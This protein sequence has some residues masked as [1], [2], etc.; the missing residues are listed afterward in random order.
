MPERTAVVYYYDGTFSGLLACIYESYYAREMPIDIIDLHTAQ[1][2]LFSGKRIYAHHEKSDRV[3]NGLLKKAGSRAYAFLRQAFLTCLPKKELA[4]LR[5]ARL[6]FTRGAEA[7][8]LL[9]H[10]A[11]VPLANA[12][13]HMRKEAELLL[14]FI[15][16]TEY[17]GILISMIEPKNQVLPL[18]ARHFCDRFNGEAFLIFDK[19]HHQALLH[20]GNHSKL[21]HMEQLNLP[22]LSEEEECLR[23]LWKQFY[24]TIGIR[25]RYNPTCRRSHMPKRYWRNMTE[26]QHPELKEVKGDFLLQQR[27]LQKEAAG[28]KQP[29]GQKMGRELPVQE[30]EKQHGRKTMEYINAVGTAR[31]DRSSCCL[32]SR[33]VEYSPTGLSGEHG[34]KQRV[35]EEDSPMV[36]C[37][38]TGRQ[39]FGRAGCH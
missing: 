25:A 7:M 13:T 19:T 2:Q 28:L 26:F 5:F 22:R 3:K 39:D 1:M 18:I 14:G 38:R 32:V 31:A 21:R 24:D 29:A 23:A 9:T 16:F 10:P 34:A 6:A 27:T 8:V 17:E 35:S 12:V 20:Y 11:M 33:K 36:Y 37:S 15:R 4:L 30:D